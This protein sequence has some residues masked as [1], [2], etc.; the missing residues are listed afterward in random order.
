[1]SEL[2][3]VIKEN[4]R[5]CFPNSR[6]GK[7]EQQLLAKYPSLPE[8][9]ER[10]KKALIASYAM[11]E[12]E[13][14][15]LAPSLKKFGSY[16]PETTFGSSP[17]QVPNKARRKS[18]KEGKLATS[19]SPALKPSNPG[20][21]LMFD[22]DDE[23]ATLSTG[24]RDIGS[25]GP[26]SS[27]SSP[28]KAEEGIWFNAKGKAITSPPSSAPNTAV[29]PFAT[30][31]PAPKKEAK[32]LPTPESPSSNWWRS[33]ILPEKF[34]MKEIMAQAS[35]STE[36]SNISL[37]LSATPEKLSQK[38]RRRQQQQVTAP[39]V[40]P[41]V[42]TPEK[43]VPKMWQTP[44]AVSRVSL[45][46]V[47][48]EESSSASKLA[49][50]RSSP[51]IGVRGE[52]H[53]TIPT[54]PPASPRLANRSISPLPGPC[55]SPARRTVPESTTSQP[56]PQPPFPPPA[57]RSEATLHF[58]LA[59]IMSQ[60][61]V[62]KEIMR[63]HVAKRSLQEIQAEQEFLRWWDM[64]SEK[65]RLEAVATESAA[66]RVGRRG[67]GGSKRGGRGKGR[68]GGRRGRGE[69]SRGEA[70]AAGQNGRS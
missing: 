19:V 32:Q 21:D 5:R 2:D 33:T 59:D 41:V 47:L 37:G 7:Q 63:D 69:S 16:P 12:D 30:R 8:A 43:P 23:D 17:Q 65:I 35:S 22:M 14:A 67:G 61:E 26:Y 20:G 28:S 6:S 48:M 36:K 58:S 42:P 57:R 55:S 4:Q 29:G 51:S 13:P 60:E 52:V 46:E 54:P 9:S 64:E 18:S 49:T 45:K 68:G 44:T 1:M 39:V 25:R 40:A 56:P 50:T 11:H 62:Q 70:V 38:E 3:A 10:E 34:P 31:R 27:P 53:M 24:A 15:L 66:S